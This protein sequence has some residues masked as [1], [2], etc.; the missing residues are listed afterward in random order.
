MPTIDENYE[1]WNNEHDW[2]KR[3]EEWTPPDPMWKKQILKYSMHRYLKGGRDVL[4]IGPG[5]GRWTEEILKSAPKSLIGIDLSDR[6]IEMCE[7]RFATFPNARFF[8]NDGKS[9][10]LVAD[11]SIDFVWSFDVFVHLEK[12]TI[13]SYAA[14][15]AR[16]MRKDATAVIH[17]PS[18]DRATEENENTA[19]RGKVT[20]SDMLGIL[21]A[22]DFTVLHDYYEEWISN[23]DSSVVIFRK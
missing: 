22:G 19:W 14:E 5:G 17:Y 10:K 7:E 23:H 18:L 20:S 1:H 8:K 15:L 13:A 16:V 2:S 9:L 4:E 6:C 12:D 11:D 21:A 3:G